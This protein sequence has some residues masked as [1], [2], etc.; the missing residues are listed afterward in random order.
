MDAKEL[1]IGNYVNKHG[2]LNIIDGIA[3]GFISTSIG[4]AIFQNKIEPILLTE[5]WLLK[6]GFYKSNV[7]ARID[8]YP[9]DDGV[10]FYFNIDPAKRVKIEYV[11]QLQTLFFALT[12]EELTFES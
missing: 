9:E 1:R 5:E 6:F 10:Y 4:G 3:I 8:L 11:H 12:G 2:N 7:T